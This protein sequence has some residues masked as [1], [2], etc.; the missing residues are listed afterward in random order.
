MVSTGKNKQQNKRLFSPLSE[1]DT[2]SMIGQNNQD[3]QI[4]S[5]Y[6]M[7]CRGI[8]SDNIGNRTQ[9]NYPQKD[10]HTPE[11]NFVRKVRSE[12]DVAMTSVETRIQDAVLT[13][14]ENLVNPR[15]ELA[16]KSANAPSGWSVDG[17]VLQPDQRDFSGN[18][19]GLR[20]T[21]S[22]KINSYSDLN[23][24]DET[25]GNITVEEGA[26]LVDE[27]N[28]DRQTYAHYTHLHEYF[29]WI[30]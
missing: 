17:N 8:S 22:S 16:M 7:I 4:K 19:E 28:I 26:L 11:E 14:I 2:D 23:R 6:N 5:R 29:L 27:K 10:V 21:A 18:I 9:V 15:M 25:R 30:T 20:R 3:E 1:R 24:I 13:E 12:V